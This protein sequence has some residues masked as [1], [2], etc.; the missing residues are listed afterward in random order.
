MG[1]EY[2][3]A[4]AFADHLG[5][6]LVVK[7]VPNQG[8]LVLWLIAGQGD[9]I[10]ATLIP[11]DKQRSEIMFSDGYLTV[12]QKVVVRRYRPITDIEMLNQKNIAVPRES[13]S[14]ESLIRVGQKNVSFTLTSLPHTKTEALLYLVSRKAIDATV[15]DSNMLKMYQRYYPNLHAPFSIAVKQPVCWGVRKGSNDLCR[16]INSFFLKANVSGLFDKIYYK[17][18]GYIEPLNTTDIIHFKR[19]LAKHLPKYIN[20]IKKQA[21]M[22]NLD[23]RL[24][25]AQ[26]Y[27]ESHF[28]SF[29]R[30]HTRVRGIMQVTQETAKEVGVENVWDPRHCIAGGIRYLKKLYDS[31]E[32]LE[33]F[34][35]ICMALASYNLGR[36]HIMDAVDIAKAKGLNPY[37]WADLEKVIPLLCRRVYYKKTTYGYCRG[38]EGVH[39]VRSILN[40]YD[41]LKK[42]MVEY[43]EHSEYYTKTP[44]IVIGDGLTRNTL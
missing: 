17:Y 39:Y 5:I 15:A 40:Y 14:E 21:E 23:W 19:T 32:G 25:V 42:Q 30:S 8:D 1:F 31:F 16:E 26:I 13:A 38:W 33:E 10:A 22:Y 12:D 41:I 2:E 34:D 20:V 35:R 24:I 44:K 3:L 36:G 6:Q 4:R 29:A 27:Q 18:F 28:N 7:V 37:N 9:F 11:T 43:P